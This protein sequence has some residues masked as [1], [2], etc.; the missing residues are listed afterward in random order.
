M[1]QKEVDKLRYTKIERC[2]KKY[3]KRRID[4]ASTEP[5]KKE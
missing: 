3:R 2:S 5:I 1:G 4:Y